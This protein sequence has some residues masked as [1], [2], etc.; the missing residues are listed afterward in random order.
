MF[1]SAMT[2]QLGEPFGSIN[3]TET[4]NPHTATVTYRVSGNDLA[5]AILIRPSEYD[6]EPVPVTV[7]VQ[8]G[9]GDYRA[10]LVEEP[11]TVD[12]IA[13][14]DSVRVDPNQPQIVPTIHRQDAPA[15]PHGVRPV[16]ATTQDR[17]TVVIARL[18]EQWIQR[19]DCETMRLLV[20]A[21]KAVNQLTY[22]HDHLT[23]STNRMRELAND[24]RIRTDRIHLLTRLREAG[25]TSTGH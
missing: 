6:P 20:A 15:S 19:E 4:A 24:I 2:L 23:A 11:F 7:T 16:Q 3:F 12:G 5:G 14:A 18:V 22:E 9:R 17:L 1:E 10:H 21:H 8:L 13:V 25:K